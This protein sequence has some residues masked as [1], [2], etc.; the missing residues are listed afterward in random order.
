MIDALISIN[1]SGIGI[2]G[3]EPLC[4]PYIFELLTYSASKKIP[5]AL[6]T[7]GCFR[8]NKAEEIVEK[9]SRIPLTNI[10]ISIDSVNATQF[11][12]LR[13]TL[14]GLATVL[15]FAKKMIDARKRSR[16]SMKITA[17]CVVSRDNVDEIP[18]IVKKTREVGFDSLGFM[19]LH[20]EITSG[21]EQRLLCEDEIC[22]QRF[23]EVLAKIDDL[24]FIDNS[25][26]YLR[27]FPA[28]FA[29]KPFPYPCTAGFTVVFVDCGCNVYYCGPDFELDKKIANFS[30][31]DTTLKQIWNSPLYTE[32]RR[33]MSSCRC[34]YWNCQAELNVLFK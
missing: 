24:S 33:K 2:S 14:D 22:L 19:P 25:T 15:N 9:L 16:G 11:D 17:M 7:N 5:V 12:R 23:S 29:G 6:N 30:T 20:R 13:G 32:K 21:G 4:Y 34:C 31:Q 10:N 3:G 1:S 26:D 18:A 8:G 27:T 28:A